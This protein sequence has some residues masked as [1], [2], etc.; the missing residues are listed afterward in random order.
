MNL[1]NLSAQNKTHKKLI[2]HL[3]DKKI[4]KVFNQFSKNIGF[5]KNLAVAASGGPDSLSL[6]FLAKCF[7][8]KNNV[9]VKCYIVNHQ[10]RKNSSEESLIVKN[11]IK[12]IHID[13]KILTWNGKK[14]LNNIQSKARDKRY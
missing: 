2:K 6:A 8:L 3:K 1:K 14:P 12:K 4:L 10:L 7:A 13:C 11:M 5:K 9:K